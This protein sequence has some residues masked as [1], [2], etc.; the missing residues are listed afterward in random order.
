MLRGVTNYWHIDTHIIDYIIII[1][2]DYYNEIISSR[3]PENSNLKAK[4]VLLLK[5][6]LLSF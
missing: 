2:H 1:G 5:Y 4:L 3:V 6:I